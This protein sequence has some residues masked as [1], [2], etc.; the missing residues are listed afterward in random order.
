MKT[1]ERKIKKNIPFEAL[2]A[3]LRQ[4]ADAL[5]GRAGELSTE[6]ADLPS[7]IAKLEVKGKAQGDEWTLKIKIKAEPIASLETL[8][9]EVAAASHPTPSPAGQS[10]LD[11]KHLKK[12]MKVAFKEIGASLAAKKRPKQDALET[13][14]SASDLMMT[15]T[16]VAYGEDHY[17][18]YRKACQALRTAYE[19]ENM[20]ALKAAYETLAQLKKESHQACK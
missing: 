15:F 6:W 11:Y 18:A 14:L 17:P 8:P 16:G 7:P 4:L 10:D 9:A 12:Q 19:I 5:D 3:Q 2:P 20:A 1:S 13:F